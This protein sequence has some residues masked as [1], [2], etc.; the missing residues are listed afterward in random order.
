MK[1]LFSALALMTLLS[2][3]IG[4]GDDDD[5][6]K[7]SMTLTIDGT[8]Q[9]VSNAA[10]VLAFET[11]YD[12]EGRAVVIVGEVGDNQITL[13]VANWDFQEPPAD[14]VKSKDYSVIMDE[15]TPETAQCLELEG[16]V[17][18]CDGALV[19]YMTDTDV[20]YSAIVEDY[21]GYIKVTSCSGKRISGEFDVKAEGQ[22]ENVITMKGTFTNIPY[23]VTPK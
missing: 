14:A 9:K 21:Q 20:F 6:S 15:N 7:S 18:L 17:F 19:T 11:Q 5:S 13:S 1:K 4:C 2:A 16:D 22:D 10:G 12:H 23:I 3:F 8:G